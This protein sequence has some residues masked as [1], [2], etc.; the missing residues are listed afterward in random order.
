MW[1]I[2]GGSC[3][4]VCFGIWTSS[5]SS[6]ICSKG[7]PFS[8]ELLFH[9]C[10]KSIGH[11]CVCL[12]LDSSF[13][14]IGLYVSLHIYITLFYYC[15][16]IVH[17]FLT[18]F[19]NLRISCNSD[20]FKGKY[21]FCILSCLEGKSNLNLTLFIAALLF[22]PPPKMDKN[23]G[24]GGDTWPRW[25]LRSLWG[26][27]HTVGHSIYPIFILQNYFC[28]PLRYTKQKNQVGKRISR[29]QMSPV[30]FLQREVWVR[31]SEQASILNQKLEVFEKKKKLC[32]CKAALHHFKYIR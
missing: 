18:V 1:S 19:Q 5:C 4:F 28:W 32:L 3:W 9:L 15:S 20:T 10:Q 22:L 25:Y 16:I 27:D 2:V 24:P 31:C 26:R 6:P 30:M 23:Q 12:F 21:Y 13:C 8:I 29:R 11:I 7:W 14:S 17:F